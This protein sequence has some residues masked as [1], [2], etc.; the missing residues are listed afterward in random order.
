[1]RSALRSACVVIMYTYTP[2]RHH[3]CLLPLFVDA[4]Q[5]KMSQTPPGVLSEGTPQVMLACWT[6]GGDPIRHIY[7]THDADVITS[8][9]LH[10]TKVHI[11][12]SAFSS[13]YCDNLLTWNARCLCV[14][15]LPTPFLYVS[16]IT[17]YQSRISGTGSAQ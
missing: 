13:N 11:H 17:S 12:F 8:S 10:I 1:M 15:F 14:Y 5:I 4:P 7:W 16:L 6:E 3:C 9:R 2:R